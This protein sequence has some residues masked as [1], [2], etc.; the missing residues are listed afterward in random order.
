MKKIIIATIL[1]LTLI[2]CKVEE[3]L[4]KGRIT[5]KETQEELVGAKIKAGYKT[6]YTN[7][8]GE[9]EI[10]TDKDSIKIILISYQTTFIK[11][12]EVDEISLSKV[13]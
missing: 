9:F 5:D 4:I 11:S 12:E 7:M 6:A 13:K 10:K 2:S 8:Q 1:T 3:K